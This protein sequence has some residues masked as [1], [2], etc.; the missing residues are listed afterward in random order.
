M[1]IK[2]VPRAPHKEGCIC[3]VC[4][5]KRAKLEAPPESEM[6]VE[7][8]III[9]SPPPSP[10][11]EV[12]LDSLPIATKFELSGQENR[13]GE[14]IE[15]MVVCYNLFINDTMTLSGATMVKPIK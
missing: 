2:G 13:V 11:T 6:A 12:R 3:V 1:V 8:E 7:P 10:P 4:K 9:A 15:G 14:M 5:A